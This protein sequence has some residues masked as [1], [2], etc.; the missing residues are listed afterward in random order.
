MEDSKIAAY[1]NLKPLKYSTVEKL[2]IDQPIRDGGRMF[3][4]LTLRSRNEA[5]RSRLV[6]SFTKVRNLKLDPYNSYLDFSLLL[7]VGLDD[8][9]EEVNY[10]V[11][12]DEQDVEFSF[13][14]DDFTAAIEDGD[15]NQ[16]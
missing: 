1:H 5:D 7:I 12:N 3:L 11:F 2:T 16:V 6:L 13:I 15:R 10:K 8:G 4:V 14:C 9:W